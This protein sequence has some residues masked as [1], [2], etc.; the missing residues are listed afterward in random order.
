MYRL[1]LGWIEFEYSGNPYKP[2][3]I[4]HE[5]VEELVNYLNN[6]EFKNFIKYFENE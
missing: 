3:K 2:K 4:E 5:P 6:N 1:L